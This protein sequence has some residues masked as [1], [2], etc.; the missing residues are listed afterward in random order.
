[1]AGSVEGN[2]AHHDRVIDTG[3]TSAGQSGADFG[4]KRAGGYAAAAGGPADTAEN[5]LAAQ[6]AAAGTEEEMRLLVSVFGTVSLVVQV[7]CRHDI[8]LS[9][10][11][12][13]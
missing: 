8:C 5:T 12:K 9:I 6:A 4:Q 1:V 10:T 13:N 3:F 7:L 2:C 11:N